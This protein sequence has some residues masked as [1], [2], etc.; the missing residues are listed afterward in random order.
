[1]ESAIEAIEIIRM[2][3]MESRYKDVVINDIV[4]ALATHNEDVTSE[5][6]SSILLSATQ[7]NI[8]V[9]IFQKR[10]QV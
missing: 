4:K 10:Y 3:R 7:Y 5:I 2:K 6:E 9:D 8:D 1:M